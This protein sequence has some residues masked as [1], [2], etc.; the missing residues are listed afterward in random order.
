MAINTK[1]Q[2][3]KEEELNYLNKDFSSFQT[4]LVRYAKT[5]YSDKIQDFSESGLGGLFIDMAAYVGDVLSFYLD[6]QFG[7]LDIQTAIEP[8]N[9]ARIAQ[10]AGIELKGASPA[11]VDV[12]FY[13]KIPSKLV[14]GSYVPDPLYLFKILQGTKVTTTGNLEFELG[15]N[16]DFAKRDK[17]GNLLTDYAIGDTDSSNN[18]ANFI[19]KKTGTCI[20]SAMFTEKFNI[21]NS[22]KS[23]RTIT[24]NQ[25]NI[26]E[27]VSIVDSELNN[28][29]EVDNLAQDTIFESVENSAVDDISQARANLRVVAAPRRFIKRYSRRT[30]KTTIIF[31]GGTS[32]TYDDNVIPNPSDHAIKLFGD[33]KHFKKI[34]LDPNTLLT[35]NTL[36]VA[37]INTILTVKYRAGGGLKFNVPANTI[38][39][40]KTLLTEFDQSGIP[41]V[42]RS[43]RSSV[44]VDNPLRALGGTERLSD[45]DLRAIVTSGVASQGRIVSKKDMI[46][47]VYTM[48]NQFG[49]FFR[50]GVRPDPKNANASILSGI[51]ID[52]NSRLQYATDILKNNTATYLDEFRIIGDAIDILDAPVVNLKIKFV[53]SVMSKFNKQNVVSNAIQRLKRNLRI[54]SMQI[55]QPINISELESTIQ[56]TEGVN[57]VVSFEIENVTGESNSL[58]YIGTP[59]SIVENIVDR[60][61]Y[62]PIGGIFEVRY[63][64]NDIKGSAS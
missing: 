64:N 22:A 37:P 5:H 8:D 48:P 26:N 49:R 32:D 7:E 15:E 61:L 2:K 16:I 4:D 20:S 40:T 62:P 21:D 47:R 10:N 24:L 51:C 19:L 11:V 28:Y 39:N 52:S 56:F 60:M 9:I 53:V 31:G 38:T 59:Y 41:S 27:I 36:G 34:N 29:Y 23:F 44:E 1:K 33:R 54:E 42:I 18:P 63:P 25:S 30:G 50:V 43:V 35:S 14:K 17:L 3:K 55:D 13:C 58:N 57:S 45:D 6:H 46:S 12:D